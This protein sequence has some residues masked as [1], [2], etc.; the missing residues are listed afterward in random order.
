MFR[1]ALRQ[2]SRAVAAASATGR[3]ASVSL[4]HPAR[5]QRHLIESILQ[6]RHFHPRIKLNGFCHPISGLDNGFCYSF[7]PS[8]LRCAA[9]DKFCVSSR[10]ARLSPAPS[11]LPPSR[12][13]RTPLRLRPLP[14]RSLPSLS[15]ESVVF[16]R[17]LVSLRLDVSSPSGT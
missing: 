8:Y 14:P 17:K 11:V 16:R 4:S 3:V 10:L 6:F 5:P 2:S 12:S 9:V 13:V 7:R 15:R 1:N